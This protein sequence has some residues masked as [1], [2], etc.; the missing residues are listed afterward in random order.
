MNL[1][2]YIY[3]VSP[4]A[5]LIS[6]WWKGKAARHGR[7]RRDLQ[8]GFLSPQAEPIVCLAKDVGSSFSTIKNINPTAPSS[9]PIFNSTLHSH[10]WTTQRLNFSPIN[11]N[12]EPNS[13]TNSRSSPDFVHPH[14]PLP[15]MHLLHYKSTTTTREQSLPKPETRIAPPNNTHNT[16][17]SIQFAFDGF[18]NQQNLK[19]NPLP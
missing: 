3:N 2:K 11:F 10:P 7:A 17:K 6:R 1:C 5:L 8:C 18:R 14:V 16:L 4:S 12:N 9:F 19:C 15:I 13:N